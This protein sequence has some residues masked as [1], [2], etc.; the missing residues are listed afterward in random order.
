MAG[1]VSSAVAAAIVPA[2]E[3]DVG[4]LQSPKLAALA[5]TLEPALEPA[6]LAPAP[7]VTTP[8]VAL[9][10]NAHP[11]VA[12]GDEPA[13]TRQESTAAV[14]EDAVAATVAAAVAAAAIAEPAAVAPAC[15]AAPADSRRSQSAPKSTG[16][17]D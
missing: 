16:P 9:I 15:A 10:S 4:H 6:Q 3:I 17:A 11:A 8:A 7:S 5:P 14:A 1:C 12:A 13:T 2:I